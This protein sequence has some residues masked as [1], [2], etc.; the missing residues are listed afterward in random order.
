MTDD[1]ASGVPP[2]CA[3]GPRSRAEDAQELRAL[4]PATRRRR[5][6]LSAVR[7]AVFAVLLLAACNQVFD[8]DPTLLAPPDSDADSI[9]DARDNCVTTT[10]PDQADGDGDGFGDACDRCLGLA[11]S[12]NHDE[13]GDRRGDE[14]DLCPIAPDLG[15]DFDGDGVGDACEFYTGAGAT[16]LVVFDPLAS[17]APGWQSEGVPW[18]IADDAITPIDDTPLADPGL[19][20]TDVDVA[21]PIWKLTAGVISA[22]PW[23]AGDHVGIGLVGADGV[24]AKCEIACDANGCRGSLAVR[25][26]ALMTATVQQRAITAVTLFRVQNQQVVCLAAGLAIVG[27]EV[28]GGTPVVFGSPAFA[29]SHFGVWIDG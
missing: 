2:G 5:D 3:A 11:T 28:G 14:C 8:L 24:L 4:E 26:G 7:E 22:R 20:R 10:N 6:T 12:S 18:A 1:C 29:L 15:E 25:G 23:Q 9:D 16:R 21:G 17:L 13:D 27:P 19:V